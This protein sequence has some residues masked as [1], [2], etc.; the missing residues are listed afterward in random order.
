MNRKIIE[1]RAVVQK[2]VPLLTGRGLQVTQRGAQA[3]VRADP[4]TRKPILINIPNIP[5][6][7]TDEFSTS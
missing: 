1:L 3:F 7:A 6:S 4:K 5:E 2:L